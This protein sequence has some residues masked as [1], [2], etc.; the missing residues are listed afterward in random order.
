MT[1]P[2]STPRPEHVN[3]RVGGAAVRRDPAT[4]RLESTSPPL[5]RFLACV[6]KTAACWLWTGRIDRHGYGEFKAEG[7]K[8]RAHRWMYEHHSGA[9]IPDGMVMDHLCRTRNC[10]NPA[11]LE[12]TTVRE[13][14]RRGRSAN[15]EKTHCINSHEYSPE[16]TYV[17]PRGGRIC[18]TCSRATKKRSREAKRGA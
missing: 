13:N 7:R 5:E 15:R 3:G 18:R 4:G 9:P 17:S 6:Q 14:T 2:S 16:N 11:H 8:V 12:V 10:V 1:G